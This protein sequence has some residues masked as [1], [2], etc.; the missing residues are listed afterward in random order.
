MLKDFRLKNTAFFTQDLI[1]SISFAALFKPGFVYKH[2]QTPNL[3]MMDLNSVFS[4]NPY[5]LSTLE[6][7]KNFSRSLNMNQLGALNLNNLNNMN[8]A[9]NGV[10]FF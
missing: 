4:N 2:Q 6:S 9:F 10:I 3:G 5:I 1:E 7:F 8:L